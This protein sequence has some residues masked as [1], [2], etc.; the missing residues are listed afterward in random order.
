MAGNY[1]DPE[2]TRWE[3]IGP[4]RCPGDPRPHTVDRVR[5]LA[6]LGYGDRARIAVAT[7]SGGVEAGYMMTVLVGV[8]E[9]NLVLPD[10][11]PRPITL[12]QIGRLDA[13]TLLGRTTGRGKAEQVVYRGIL[14]CLD[15]AW[16][17]DPL[18]NGSGAPSADGSSGRDTPTQTTSEP[19]SSTTT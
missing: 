17:D 4:C 6:Q 11:S 10:G 7:R 1:A 15:P 19:P 2:E 18:P 8:K 5:V 9:W 3:E 14:I 16:A 13:V 12:E